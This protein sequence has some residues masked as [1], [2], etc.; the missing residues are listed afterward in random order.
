M[1]KKLS[2]S[3]ILMDAPLKEEGSATLSI[4]KNG[5]LTIPKTSVIKYG[6]NDA[7]I[8]IMWDSRKRALG[9]KRMNGEV[10]PDAEWTKTMRLLKVNPTTGQIQVSI[11]RIL[12]RIGVSGEHKK[13][14]IGTAIDKFQDKEI[15]YVIVPENKSVVSP[16]TTPEE[17]TSII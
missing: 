12:N 13:L 1:P 10:L 11:G 8:D 2:F 6:L 17:V 3:N 4:Q 14:E 7:F 16:V 9:L 5:Q 15:L